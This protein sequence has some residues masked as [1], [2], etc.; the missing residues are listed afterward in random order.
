[1]AGQDHPENDQEKKPKFKIINRRRIDPDEIEA[2]DAPPEEPPKKAEVKEKAG[3]SEPSREQTPPEE[4]PKAADEKLKEEPSKEKKSYRK[5]EDPLEYL[6]I[7]VSFLQ[8]LVSV[9]W[10][11]LGLVPH[12]QTQL[13]A[14]KLEEARKAIDLYEKLLKEVDKDLPP[15]LKVE[16]ERIL[17]EMKVNYVNQLG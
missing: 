5:G 8:T 6:N 17:Q 13:V 1:M 10:V 16:L 2:S 14:K 4:A 12:P 7:V 9:V 15:Q 3:E 11:H